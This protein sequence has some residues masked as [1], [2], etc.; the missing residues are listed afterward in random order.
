MKRKTIKL[1]NLKKFQKKKRNS[2]WIEF[3]IYIKEKIQLK[4]LKK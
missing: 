2:R 1:V 4:L 3:D